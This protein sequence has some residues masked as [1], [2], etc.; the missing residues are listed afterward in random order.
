MPRLFQSIRRT[1]N[2]W[3]LNIALW[4]PSRSAMR[5]QPV[6]VTTPQSLSTNVQ[7][8]EG[9]HMN[10]LAIIQGIQALEQL[11]PT[12]LS[13][14]NTVHPGDNQASQKATTAV[15][16]TEAALTSAGVA[17]ETY[18]QLRPG[19]VAAAQA[20]LTIPRITPTATAQAPAAVG[21]DAST[22]AA[23]VSGTSQ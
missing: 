14:V 11:M 17:A 15:A 5:Y 7:S 2:L 3:L 10:L 1:L 23:A 8:F 6:A 22:Q 13:F 12:V 18:A 4:S 16:M 9:K 19:I 20:P 21:A